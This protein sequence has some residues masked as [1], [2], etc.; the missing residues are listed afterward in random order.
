MLGMAYRSLAADPSPDRKWF[1]LD[2]P[3]D[4]GWIE[5]VNT[6]K[7][8]RSGFPCCMAASNMS[9]CTCN[10]AGSGVPGAGC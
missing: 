10:R 5:N 2:G 8:G 6:G 3:V 9:A 7:S 1:V 4:A